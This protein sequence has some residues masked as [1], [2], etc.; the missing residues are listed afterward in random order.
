MKQYFTEAL[1][2]DLNTNKFILHSNIPMSYVPG[3]PI[4]SIMNG[5]L[6]MK[7]PYLKYKIT[8]EVDKT[9]IYPIKYLVT[10]SLPERTIVGIEDFAYNTT[11]G[12]VE[13][14]MPVG[15]FRHDAIKKLD[16]KAYGSLRKALYLEYDKVINHLCGQSGY[17]ANDEKQFKSLF[18]VL[19]EPSLAPFYRVIDC[20]FTNQYFISKNS[21]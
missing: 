16:K 17:S 21:I 19:I 2:H 5:N 13:F 14:N 9:F 12:N 6:C 18:N 8:G 3:L 20:D 4:L 11:F 7:I 1:I 15:L 10:I